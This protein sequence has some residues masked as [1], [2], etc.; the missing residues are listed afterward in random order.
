MYRI[1]YFIKDI[2]REIR[3]HWQRA[4]R[5]YADCD[6]WNFASYISKIMD[7]GLKDFGDNTSGFPMNFKSD[8][9]WVKVIKEIRK[10]FTLYNGS[11]DYH[12][13]DIKRIIKK[14]KDAQ[15]ALKRSFQLLSKFFVNLWD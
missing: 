10:G 4:F 11:N 13:C 6:L 3:W 9:D 14:H 8:K 15:V 2:P 12:G 1:Y 5:G 7:R